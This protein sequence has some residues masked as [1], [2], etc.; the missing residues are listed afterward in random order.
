[1]DRP[2]GYD[3]P[4]GD[5]DS[6]GNIHN[7]TSYSADDRGHLLDMLG[8][9]APDWAYYAARRAGKCLDASLVANEA[10]FQRTGLSLHA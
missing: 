10:A 2:D 7:G 5:A 9:D 4:V 8:P 3:A 1:V 6:D